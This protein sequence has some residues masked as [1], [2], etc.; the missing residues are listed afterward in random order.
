M[1]QLQTAIINWQTDQLGNTVPTSDTFDDVYF[2]HA[3]GLNE[4]HYVFIEGNDLP[5]RLTKLH[6]N[7]VFVVAETGFGTGLNFLALC[8]FWNHL[9]TQGKLNKTARLHF[10]STEKFP[11]KQSDL[12]KALDSW[13][14]QDG[15]DITQFINALIDQYPLPLEG[16]HRLYVR[17]DVVLDLWFGDALTS[18][19]IIHQ[20]R[21]INPN[22]TPKVNAWFLDGFT[23]SKN[24]ELWS[25]ELFDTIKKLSADHATLATFTSAGFV[26][27]GLQVAGFVMAKKKGFGHKR[28]M[29]TGQMLAQTICSRDDVKNNN[30]AHIAIIGAGVSGL[31]SAY[32]LAQ[33]GIKVTLLD[34][35]TPPSGASGNP[36]AMFAPKLSLIEQAAHHLST[37]SFLYATRLYHKLNQLADVYAPLGVVDFLLPTQKSYDK[38]HTLISPYPNQLIHEIKPIYPNQTI[39]AFVPQAGLINPKKLAEAIL[40]HPLIS[41]QKFVVQSIVHND[42]G[43]ILLGDN[44]KLMADKAIISSGHQSHML[45]D[46]LFNPRKIRGQVSWLSVDDDTFNSL[47]NH[48]IKYDGYCAKFDEGDTKQF[49]IGAS[50]VRNCTNTN[51]TVDE[52]KFNIS[53]LTH[54]LPHITKK[55]N[56]STNAL[57]GR[58]GIRAQTPDYHP[59]V[60]K[61]DTHIYTIYGMGSKGFTFAPLCGEILA[62]MI[63]DEILPI[64]GELLHKISPQR[65]RLSTLLMDNEI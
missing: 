57:K 22:L 5:S 25:D 23:P 34:K 54:S 60:G 19:Q 21:S 18:F 36:R 12:Q 56:L 64:S 3:G 55:L 28:E 4:S 29:L 48:P 11:L 40:C 1:S 51:I 16:C 47:P 27:R 17:N 65:S 53:K 6:D 8:K 2:S 26:R 61:I 41:W 33:R 45:H 44:D 14:N 38:L 62:G 7:E 58:A 39:H 46:N 31:C 32:A 42:D 15:D 52:H 43:I 63:C 10:I 13:R 37:V 30:L 49:L 9:K 59:I 35:N 24:S 50:F 20:S